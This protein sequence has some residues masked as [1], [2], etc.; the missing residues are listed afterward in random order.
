MLKKR[1]IPIQLL[2]NHR[3][4]KT[5]N[6][7]KPRD[8]GDP[9]TS[10]KVYSD[11]DVD[12][13]ILLHIDR[14]ENSVEFLVSMVKQIAKECF[15][16]FSVG[17]GI[18]TIDDARK[19]LAAGADKVILNSI[20]LKEPN[21]I[22]EISSLSGTQAVVVAIDVK[23]VRGK[24]KIYSNCGKTPEDCLLSQHIQ[25]VISIGAGEIMIQS[26]DR[27]GEMKG[28]DLDLLEAVVSESSVPVIAA[29]GAGNFK[30]LNDALNLG[31][32]AVACGS[33]FNFG[34]NNPLR[35]KAFLKNLGVPLKRIK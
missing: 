11:Q 12:E 6:F 24:Y 19:L 34:D 23:L 22:S 7:T 27:D 16:P 3:L 32:S 17:G 25:N 4:V 1:I 28:Y 31:V 33:L 8:V 20:A 13:L 21:I 35:A 15:V 30:H 2:S 18:K 5:M 29:G 9:I 10:S 14:I 26:I